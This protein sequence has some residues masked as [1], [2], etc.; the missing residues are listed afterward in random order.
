MSIAE[1]NW[2]TG[3]VGGMLIGLSATIM[4]AF[5]GR[6]AGISGMVNN[7]LTFRA[8]EAWRWLF[9]GGMLAGAAIYEYLLAAQP[10]PAGNFVPWAMIAGGFIV[11]FGTRMGNGCT[12]GHGVCG[13]GR[14]SP[15]SLVAV[16]TFMATGMLTVFIFRQL[17]GLVY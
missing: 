12:S 16:V 13:L 1:F 10:T 6:I 11:G 15:R 9:L 4:L 2:I 17:F 14:R 8:E 3:L 7:A 5:S